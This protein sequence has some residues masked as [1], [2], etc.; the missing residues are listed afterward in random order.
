[1]E[2]IYLYTNIYPFG[3]VAESFVYDE[4]KEAV[5][6]GI[7]LTIIPVNKAD[8]VRELPENVYLDRTICDFGLL[9]KLK[10]FIKIFSIGC[11]KQVFKEES[12]FKKGFILKDFIKYLY[13]ANLVYID[14]EQRAHEEEPSIFYSYWMSYPPI[15]FAFYKCYHP[16]TPHKFI[17]RGHASDIYVRKDVYYP[18]RNFVVDNIDLVC[19]I[20]D[21]GREY[22]KSL[23][24]SNENKFELFRL[25]VYDN[26]NNNKSVNTGRIEIISCSTIIARKRVN[27][28]FESLKNYAQSHP[29]LSINWTHIG[30][31]PLRNDLQNNISQTSLPSNFTLELKGNLDNHEILALYRNKKFHCHILL[32][33]QEGIPVALMESIASGTPIIATDVD[34]VSEIANNSTG[35]LIEVDF[36]QKD[37]NAA[38]DKVIINNKSLSDSAYLFFKSFFDAKTNYTRFFARINQL[39][40]V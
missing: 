19:V 40:R 13:A 28:V 2:N 29:Q 37:F 26:Y 14:L 16:N 39:V 27:L 23:Y 7:R 31:G 30:D 12:F 20:S 18:L 21:Y 25:G 32:S 9:T 6:S 22:L 1:M 10:A 33:I 11:L 15:A 5:Q 17:S 35:A 24:G 4:A 36:E 3:E 38:L 8:V 34:G